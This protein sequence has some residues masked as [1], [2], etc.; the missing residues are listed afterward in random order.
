M[1]STEG[2]Y[3][4]Y[5]EVLKQLWHYCGY[6]HWSVIDVSDI[7]P[8]LFFIWELLLCLNKNWL[9]S[10]P[11]NNTHI[12]QFTEKKTQRFICI[13]QVHCRTT[14]RPWSFV[15]GQLLKKWCQEDKRTHGQFK[16]HIVLP[17][18]YAVF[19]RLCRPIGSRLTPRLQGFPRFED[20]SHT[21]GVRIQPDCTRFRCSTVQTNTSTTFAL[22]RVIR[23]QHYMWS[24]DKGWCSSNSKIVPVE[25]LPLMVKYAQ[26]FNKPAKSY[27]N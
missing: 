23:P 10:L 24:L 19:H 20:Q 15:Q 7:F 9:Y 5:N 26:P 25:L 2:T 17:A 12:K 13:Q 1:Q 4:R 16:T 21:E 11:L 22:R 3:A 8:F 14:I 6:C 27:Y 18:I